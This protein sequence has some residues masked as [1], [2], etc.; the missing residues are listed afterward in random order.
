[1]R[2]EPPSPRSQL[3]GFAEQQAWLQQAEGLK[4]EGNGKY[5]QGLY[6]DAIRCYERAVELLLKLRSARLSPAF[7]N[8]L[9]PT[10]ARWR[11]LVPR[12]GHN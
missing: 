10:C 7:P 1:M 5:K 11:H 2:P 9:S 12:E 4:L 3:Q 8:P 6:P